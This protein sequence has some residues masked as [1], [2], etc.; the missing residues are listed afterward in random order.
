MIDGAH[1][2]VENSIILDLE[3]NLGVHFNSLNIYETLL[4]VRCCGC[5][6]KKDGFHA[7]KQLKIHQG[8][9]Y[10]LCLHWV[11]FALESVLH[12]PCRG[13]LMQVIT[14]GDFQLGPASGRLW[15]EIRGR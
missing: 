1:A 10:N 12:R 7:F 13:Q 5:K 11:F 8:D 14:S 2:L 3:G 4:G 9:R 6:T 15:E